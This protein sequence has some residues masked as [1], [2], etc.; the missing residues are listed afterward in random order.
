MN[1]K[2]EPYDR[3]AVGERIQKR[4]QSL[5]LSQEALAERL[6]RA[7]KYCSDIERGTCGMST[8]TMLAFSEQL[9]MSLDYM[10]LGKGPV[11]LTDKPDIEA[12][13]LVVNTP[14]PVTLERVE[15]N[16]LME[17][18]TERQYPYAVKLVELFLEATGEETEE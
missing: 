18:C 5:G 16:H 14:T 11:S 6:D 15:M 2:K 17:Q 12:A 13:E 1:R 3:Y 10:M 8:E 7:A 9:D 4:R